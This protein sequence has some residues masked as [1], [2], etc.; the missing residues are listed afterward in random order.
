VD[1]VT[2]MASDFAGV[3]AAIRTYFDGFY[4]SDEKKLAGLF[5]KDAKLF[6]STDGKISVLPLQDYLALVEKRDPVSVSKKLE[7]VLGVAFAGPDVAVVR[8]AVANA[9][10]S[11]SDFLVLVRDSDGW[12]V[13]TKAYWADPR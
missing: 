4:A 8:L 10:T 2:A 1:G 9:T 3:H 11:F 5:H 7:T 12:R 6:T 13:V